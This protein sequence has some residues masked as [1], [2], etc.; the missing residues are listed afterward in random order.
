[1]WLGWYSISP[2]WLAGILGLLGTNKADISYLWG[3]NKP[4]LVGFSYLFEHILL[5][6]ARLLHFLYAI[7]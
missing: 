1:M 2:A 3:F 4:K 7:A 5:E 6:Y